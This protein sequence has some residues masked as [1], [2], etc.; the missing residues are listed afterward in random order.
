MGHHSGREQ[1]VFEEQQEMK[2]GVMPTSKGESERTKAQV[3]LSYSM[4]KPYLNIH[5][6]VL[7]MLES[8]SGGLNFFFSGKVVSNTLWLAEFVTII[9]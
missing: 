6:T 4:F 5:P 7:E 3:R 9:K 8:F 2:A 1:S